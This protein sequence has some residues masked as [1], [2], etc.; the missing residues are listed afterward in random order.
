MNIFG[1]FNHL[2]DQAMTSL[3][4]AIVLIGVGIFAL[5]SVRGK[6]RIPSI[7]ISLVAGGLFIWGGITG[8]FWMRDQA[9]GT[10]EAT[11][12][13]STSIVETASVYTAEM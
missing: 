9:K 12:Y 7:L 5:G 1:W 13:S 10:I 2:T 8:V 6:G 3:N 4:V 11:A